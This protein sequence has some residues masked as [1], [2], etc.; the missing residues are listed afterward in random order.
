MPPQA[1]DAVDNTKAVPSRGLPSTK[2]LYFGA[3]STQTLKRKPSVLEEEFP[4]SSPP[5]ASASPKRTRFSESKMPRE[6]ASTPDRSPRSQRKEPEHKDR[7][8]PL[9]VDLDSEDEDPLE[10]IPEEKNSLPGQEPSEQESEPDHDRGT[11]QNIFREP[12]PYIDF[13]VAP[14]GDDWEADPQVPESPPPDTASSQSD[15]N[16]QVD[17]WIDSYVAKGYTFEQVVSA[18]K[19]TSIDTELSEK[20]LD[21]VGKNGDLPQDWKGVWTVADDEDLQSADARKV[22]RLQNKHGE[23][24][25][26]ARFEFLE[27]YEAS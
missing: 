15:I 17:A 18:L 2:P 7:Y 8:S 14:P 23:D 21:M 11:T 25:F 10:D 12:S 24:I 26:N 9:F 3:D 19:A 5:E 1:A 4:S 13:D 20:V 16:A 6:I 27:F 22:Q